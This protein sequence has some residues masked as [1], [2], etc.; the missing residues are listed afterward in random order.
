MR[1]LFRRHLNDAQSI[2]DWTLPAVFLR[3]AI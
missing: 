1:Q 3:A 2:A